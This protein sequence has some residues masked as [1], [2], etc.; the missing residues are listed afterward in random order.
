MSLKYP[1]LGCNNRE[2][3][4]HSTCEKYINAKTENEKQNAEI[5]K[6]LYADSAQRDYAIHRN[7]RMA[8]RTGVKKG[9]LADVINNRNEEGKRKSDSDA[10]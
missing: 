6:K 1:C 4:C 10:L 7:Y 3:G 5:K 8:K 9:R 2:V